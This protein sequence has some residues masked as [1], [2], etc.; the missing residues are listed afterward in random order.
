MFG[1]KSVD[2]YSCGVLRI[3][4]GITGKWKRGWILEALLLK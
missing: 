3:W 4:T 2:C 1:D